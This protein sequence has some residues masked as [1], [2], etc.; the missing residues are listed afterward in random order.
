MLSPYAFSG[1]IHRLPADGNG[2][3][4]FLNRCPVDMFANARH[5]A[6]RD[7]GQWLDETETSGPLFSRCCSQLMPLL[8]LPPPPSEDGQQFEPDD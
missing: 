8:L 6:T 2:V 1:G 4:A 3:V 7:F 5:W